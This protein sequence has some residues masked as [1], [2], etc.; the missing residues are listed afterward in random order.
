MAMRQPYQ[1]L[2]FSKSDVPLANSIQFNISI[3]LDM[4]H[5]F[6]CGDLQLFDQHSLLFVH[7]GQ[8]TS[9]HYMS[10]SHSLVQCQAPLQHFIQ[11]I[12][13]THLL[14]TQQWKTLG[15]GHGTAMGAL[16]LRMEQR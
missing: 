14:S 12:F 10:R 1:G 4:I 7:C 13:S 16:H 8:I 9:H 5:T 15:T 3:G 11:H 6:I 2:F